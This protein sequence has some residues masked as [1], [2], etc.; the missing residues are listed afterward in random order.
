M[1]LEN[2]YVFENLV[3]FDIFDKNTRRTHPVK[4]IEPKYWSGTLWVF[5]ENEYAV[6]NFVLCNIFDKNNPC[7]VKLFKPTYRLG[8]SSGTPQ[9]IY[10]CCRKM[11]M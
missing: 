3:L 8:V 10:S 5:P 6:W 9:S 1:F 7:A 2:E 4:L 11:Y